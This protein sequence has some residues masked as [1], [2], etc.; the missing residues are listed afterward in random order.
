MWLALCFLSPPPL[1]F[2]YFYLYFIFSVSF[3]CTPG[4]DHQPFFLLSYLSFRQALF[5]NAAAGS[6]SLSFSGSTT[7]QLPAA[8]SPTTLAAA[9]LALPTVAAVTVTSTSGANTICGSGGVGTRITFTPAPAV[10]PVS[11]ITV[12]RGTGAQT[13]VTSGY[14]CAPHPFCLTVPPWSTPYL[15][16]CESHCL[17]LRPF[18]PIFF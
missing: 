14:A 2:L 17:P 8:S 3:Y 4:P 18:A 15:C 10:L 16:Y 5:C 12:V 9:L 6:F 13:P 7:T 11:L 1:F